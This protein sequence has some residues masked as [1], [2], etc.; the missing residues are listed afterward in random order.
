MS[1]KEFSGPVSVLEQI[2]RDR[3]KQARVVF[4]TA[5]SPGRGVHSPGL[6]RG[7]RLPRLW[8][9]FNRAAYHLRSSLIFAF[10]YMYAALGGP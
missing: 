1:S 8:K 7:V 3:E 6:S 10:L 4:I 5:E 9:D 2:K